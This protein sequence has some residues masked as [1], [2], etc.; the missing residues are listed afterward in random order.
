MPHIH[1]V[2]PCASPSYPS[3]SAG[4]FDRRSLPNVTP[5]I[6]ELRLE[7]LMHQQRGRYLQFAF[8]REE[9]IGLTREILPDLHNPQIVGM[10]PLAF[11]LT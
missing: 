2:P 8:L 5:R 4:A 3:S 10:S 9:R 1:T 11:S 6:R 7:F